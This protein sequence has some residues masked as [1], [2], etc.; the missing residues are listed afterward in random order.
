VQNWEQHRR[1]LTGAAAA[2]LTIFDRESET[3]MKA[4]HDA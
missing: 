4:L 1:N 3:A 2:L